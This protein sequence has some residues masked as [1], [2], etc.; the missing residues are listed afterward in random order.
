MGGKGC[1]KEQLN[2]ALKMIAELFASNNVTKWFIAY[3]TLLGIVRE[4]SCI[5]NDDDVDIV[6]AEIEVDKILQILEENNIEMEINTR[7]FFRIKRTNEY[8]PVDFYVASVNEDGDF[9]D[10]WEKVKWSGCFNKDTINSKTLLQLKWE[11][12]TLN[13]PYNYENKLENRYGKDWKTPKQ[14]KGVLPRK[15][16]L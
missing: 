4:K 14:S 16:I 11:D 10:K 2:A 6:C 3:G 5:N 7:T 8:G 1:N 15:A 9:Y 12:I 13:L